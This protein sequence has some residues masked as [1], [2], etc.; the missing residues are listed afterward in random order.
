MQG[1]RK[2]KME[3]NMSTVEEV[4]GNQIT[5]RNFNVSPCNFQFNN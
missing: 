1:V 2:H 5:C 4:D 3:E